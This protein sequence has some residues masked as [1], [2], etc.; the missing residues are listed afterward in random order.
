MLAAVPSVVV[1]LW[2]IFVLGAVHARST[3]SRSCSDYFGWIPIFA[4]RRRQVERCSSGDRRAD[5]HDHPDHVVDL[6]RALP[7]ACRA[8]RRRR[9]SGSARR[10]GRWCATVVVPY[11]RGGVVAAI[12]L[13]LGRALGEAIAVTQVIGNFIPLKRLALRAGR[14][15]REPH[16][17]PVPGRRLEHPGR[18]ADLPRADP[19]R[20]HVRHELRRAAHRP[21]LRAASGRARTDGRRRS[22]CRRPGARGAACWRQP[23]RRARRDRS[24]RSSRSPCS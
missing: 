12:I 3:S 11:V 19:A 7:R 20:D 23:A 5:D 8:T 17:E 1:G 14:H 13:G 4:A 22:R 2:G 21:A 18:V 6:P 24:P 9:R 15:A 16:R 10:A